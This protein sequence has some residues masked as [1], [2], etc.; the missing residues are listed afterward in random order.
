VIRV[1]G[2]AIGVIWVAK[3]GE[4]VAADVIWVEEAGVDVIRVVEGGEKA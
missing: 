3:Q 2:G 4:E 1:A